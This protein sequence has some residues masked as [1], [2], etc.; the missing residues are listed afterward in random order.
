[1]GKHMR[2]TLLLFFNIVN[3]AFYRQ[4]PNTSSPFLCYSQVNISQAETDCIQSIYRPELSASKING[5]PGLLRCGKG[6]TWDGG[7]RVPA[8]AYWP[9]KIQPGKTTEVQSI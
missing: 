5:S 6:T 4:K 2:E 7:M 3:I 8:I 9:G 1:M